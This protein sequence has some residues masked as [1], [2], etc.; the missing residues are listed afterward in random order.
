MMLQKQTLLF[1]N[2]WNE[3]VQKGFNEVF[4]YMSNINNT[5]PY[6]MTK[7]EILRHYTLV[8]EILMIRDEE[9][10]KLLS[11]NFDSQ[12]RKYC[13]NVLQ[14]CNNK[15]TLTYF[16]TKWRSYSYILYDW[17]KKSFKYFDKVKKMI[18]RGGSLEEEVFNIF[19]IEIYD[20][21]KN[22]L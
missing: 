10:R 7:P 12:L 21:Y 18:N 5:T 22:S 16:V 4:S 6:Q 20:K 11:L 14:E 17:I 15:V 1:Q 13:Q 3:L 19:K 9:V 2:K 8:Y